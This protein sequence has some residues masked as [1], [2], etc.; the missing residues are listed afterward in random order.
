MTLCLNNLIA[1]YYVTLIRNV[2]DAYYQLTFLNGSGD[3]N[4]NKNED[5]NSHK[6]TVYHKQ[7][8]WNRKLFF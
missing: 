1:I 2:R 4:Y 3:E 8:V 7:I 6:K 5:V